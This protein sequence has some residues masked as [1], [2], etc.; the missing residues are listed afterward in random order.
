LT[1]K[2][3][4]F[5]GVLAAMTT[6]G[7]RWLADPTGLPITFTDD[8]GQVFQITIEGGAGTATGTVKSMPISGS[9]GSAV[10]RIEVNLDGGAS[11]HIRSLGANNNAPVISIGRIVVTGADAN[12]QITIDGLLSTAHFFAPSPPFS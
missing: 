7:G 11:L 2:G 1:D 8:A 5:W 10:G 9:L 3:S 12:S 6:W 4:D